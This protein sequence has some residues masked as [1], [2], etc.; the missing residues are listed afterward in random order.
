MELEVVSHRFSMELALLYQRFTKK[1]VFL[2]LI[3]FK[4]L[5]I[6]FA[7]TTL[8][9]KLLFFHRISKELV[10]I[11]LRNFKKLD[12]LRNSASLNHIGTSSCLSEG[13]L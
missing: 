13:S 11:C 5:V 4:A 1:L 8:R 12:I 6:F 7:P 9:K 2:R 3:N 10:L